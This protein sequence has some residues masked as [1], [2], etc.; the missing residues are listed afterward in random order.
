[1]R[2]AL[3]LGIVLSLFLGPC[4]VTPVAA[5][6]SPLPAVELSCG[7]DPVMNVHPTSDAEISVLCTVTNPTSASEDISI[8]KIEWD[9]VLV[10]MT[11]SED[12]FTL[13]AGEDDTFE[14]LFIGQTKIPATV[15]HS[16]EIEAK[17]ESWNG[18]PYG[19]LPEGFWVANTSHIGDLK[20]ESYGMVELLLSDV[21][22]RYMDTSDEVEFNFQVTNKGNADDNLEVV[23]ANAAELQ[24]AGFSFPGGTLVSEDVD[25]QGTS[26]VKSL[27]IRA[28]SEVISDLRMPLLIRAQS[29]I[30]DSAPFSEINIQLDIKSSTQSSGIDGLDSLSSD[31]TL[32]YLSIAGGAIL[33][34]LFLVVLV[35]VVSK[36]K[37]KGAV[38]AKVTHPIIL[39]E[40]PDQESTDDIDDLFSDLDEETTEADEFDDL[41]D[42][43]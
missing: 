24:A 26:S 6:G 41:F 21:T 29:T 36:K 25:Y 14:I 35:R 40:E 1:M 27:T 22:T 7:S 43:L 30:D 9:G 12:S 11:L 16:F 37:P 15:Q 13:A 23:F 17:V 31:D 18:L 28:P 2:K 4:L 20:I 39:P 38:Q 10:E 8:T 34:I 5:Q 33:V 19:Q 3:I 42:D 32:M